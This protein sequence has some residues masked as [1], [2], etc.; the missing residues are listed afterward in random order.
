MRRQGCH[1]RRVRRVNRS[2]RFENGNGTT[3][4]QRGGSILAADRPRLV[5]LNLEQRNEFDIH[6]GNLSESI[7]APPRIKTWE[8]LS[9][10][11]I[12]SFNRGLD[13]VAEDSGSHI[14]SGSLST[15]HSEITP[16]QAGVL[17]IRHSL[18]CLCGVFRQLARSTWVI[19][20]L[21]V[22]WVLM[23]NKRP[24]PIARLLRS[25]A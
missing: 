19:Q 6:E 17:Q 2:Y 3:D 25:K 10:A 5:R 13:I 18:N 23:K 20:R 16:A 12:G 15:R 1:D 9:S 7:A 4:C 11:A 8:P 21:L 14:Q 22:L 24:P